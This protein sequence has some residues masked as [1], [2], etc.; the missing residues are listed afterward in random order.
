MKY[1]K[2][3]WRGGG[4]SQVNSIVTQP[5]SSYFPSPP[6]LVIN[7]DRSLNQDLDLPLICSDNCSWP[8]S[9]ILSPCFSFSSVL[10]LPAVRDPFGIRTCFSSLI[11]HLNLT[12]RSQ[13]TETQQLS[14]SGSCSGCGGSNKIARCMAGF[15]SLIYGP[16]KNLSAGSISEE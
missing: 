9:R 1:Y 6:P 5:Q 12:W 10:H 2:V 13:K 15:R 4:R 8:W 11:N 14:R 16:N 7:Y 3:L